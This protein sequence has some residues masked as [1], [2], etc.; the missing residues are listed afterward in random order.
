MGSAEWSAPPTDGTA[1]AA[2]HAPSGS[3]LIVP[4]YGPA[5][6][7]ICDRLVALPRERWGRA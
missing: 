1:I 6:W 2:H 5:H 3:T 4:I 7:R